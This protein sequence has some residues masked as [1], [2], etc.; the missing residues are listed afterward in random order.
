MLS[1]LAEL[2]ESD[3]QLFGKPE[4]SFSFRTR[5][6]DSDELVERDYTFIHNPEWGEWT[7]CE[8][9]ERR[10]EASAA[11][12]ERNWRREKYLRWDEPEALDLRVPPEVTEK[13]SELL[14]GEEIEL[15]MP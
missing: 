11:I 4:L 15:S 12:V 14:E 1:E 10:C 5:T 8:Y 3:E 7:F 6:E 2:A 13:L 9:E